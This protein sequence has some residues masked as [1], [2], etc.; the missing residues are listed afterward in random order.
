MMII[1]SN[2]TES[3]YRALRRYVMFRYRKLHWYYGLIL[4][5]LLTFSWF[6][7]KPDATITEKISGLVG[8]MILWAVFMIVLLLFLKMMTRFRGGRFRG[9]VGPH[10]FE[11]GDDFFTE[12]NADGKIEIRLGGI[13]HIGETPTYFFVI[14]A[15][16]RGHVI[17]KKDLQDFDALHSLQSKVTKRGA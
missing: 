10:I 2:L 15:T 8:I 14:T 3:D 6:S 12:S 13:R 16:G 7:N 1:N 9:S 5:C 11:V 17:P 4:V